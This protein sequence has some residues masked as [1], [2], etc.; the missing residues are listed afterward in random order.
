LSTDFIYIGETLF[1]LVGLDYQ[2]LIYMIH[3]VA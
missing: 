1:K 2:K 3:I